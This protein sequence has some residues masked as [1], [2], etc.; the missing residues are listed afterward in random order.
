MGKTKQDANCVSSPSAPDKA[1]GGDTEDEGSKPTSGPEGPEHSAN[2]PA[3][4]A[5]TQSA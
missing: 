5:L 1:S 3:S 2:G 4:P